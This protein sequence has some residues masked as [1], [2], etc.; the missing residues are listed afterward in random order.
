[1]IIFLSGFCFRVCASSR[2][3]AGPCIVVGHR[4]GKKTSGGE[5]VGRVCYYN[6]DD[7]DGLL[8]ATIAGG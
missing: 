3:H 4:K 2:R 1:M 6:A 8:C 5:A 7:D